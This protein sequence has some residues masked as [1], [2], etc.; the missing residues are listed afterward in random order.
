MKQ[1]HIFFLFAFITVCTINSRAQS[2]PSNWQQ[3]YQK[4]RV[5]I[6]NKG[7]FSAY[8]TPETGPIAYAI[9]FGS[10]RIFFG[11]KGIRYYFLEAHQTA[12]ETRDSLRAIYASQVPVYKEKE[13]VVGK[14]AFKSDA[15]TLQ[16]MGQNEQV[17]LNAEAPQSAY[18]SYPEAS[19]CVAYKRLVYQNI[20]PFI[21]LEYTVHPLDGLKYAF[22]VRPGANPAQIQFKYDRPVS[23]DLHQDI[24]IPTAFGPVR[25]HA[26]F[27]FQGDTSRVVASSFKLNGQT[28]G[29]LVGDYNPAQTLVIDPWTQSPNFATNWDVVWEC[30]RDGAGNAYA[31]GGIMP[32][33][34]LKY[35]PSGTLLWTYSTPYDTSNVWL[36][37]FAVDNAGNAY[38]TA[39]SVA[40]IQKISPAGALLVNNPSPGG[41]LSSA[42]F[43]TI[44]FNCDETGLVIGGTGGALLQLDAVVYNVNTTTLNIS[45]QQFISNGPTTSIPPNLEEVRAITA[46]P[47]G[48]YYFMTHDTI[49]YLSDNFG[50]CPTGT[51]SFYKGPHG[52][53]WGYKCENF[54]YD[55]AGINALATTTNHLYMHRGNEIQKRSLQDGS[56]IQSNSIPGGQ[57][58]SV[59]LGGNQTGCAGLAIDACGNI[60]VGSTTGVVKYDQLLIQQAF[61]PT[62]FAVYDIEIN[63]NGELLV[64]GG[65]GTST[66]STRTGAIRS[67][68]VGAC[69]PIALTCCDAS[70]CQ[71]Q[72]VCQT[73]APIQLVAGTSGGTWSG[74][75]VSAQGLFDPLVAGAGVQTIVYTLPC[76]N[77]SVQ[78]TVSPCTGLQVCLDANGQMSV[79][80][81]VSPYTWAYF[82][83]AVNTPITNQTECQNCG[84]TWFFGQ[85]LNGFTPVTSCSTPAGYVSF[86]TG[87]TA[88]PPAAQNQLQVT[89]NTGT[90]Y[91]FLLSQLAPCVANPCAG[92]SASI[93]TQNNPSCSGAADGSLTLSL[94]NGTA[95]FTYN[96]SPVV[97]TTNSLSN[98]SSGTYTC[99]ITDVNNCTASVSATLSDPAPLQLSSSTQPTPCGLSEGSMTVQVTGAT[100][101]Y[102]YS[103]SPITNTTGTALNL[104]SGIYMVTVTD[105][106]GCWSSITDT[107]SIS[108]G[109]VLTETIT[110]SSCM[111]NNGAISV[112]VSGGTPPYTLIWNPNLGSGPSLSNLVANQTL[113]LSVMDANDCGAFETYLIPNLNDL[114]L[115]SWA[116]S[117]SILE[118]QTVVLS[119]SG[120]ISY[121]WE[122]SQELTCPTCASTNASPIITTQYIVTGTATNGCTDQDTLLITVTQ[123]CGSVFVP[124]ILAPAATELADQTI[125]VYGNCIAECNL[126]IYNRWGEVVFETADQ[127]NCW[128]GTF[129][130]KE[131]HSDVYAYKL[132][133][134]LQDGTFVDQ[135]GSIQLIR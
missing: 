24:L 37:T 30:E 100:A 119:A 113:S 74:P 22:I 27:S 59:F 53:G 50:G 58:A 129:K 135:A 54:R 18:F 70:I 93:Q 55:N 126:V 109:P 8:Q 94:S 106:N 99:A 124:T 110:A 128:D 29:F 23:L 44:A 11:T 69:A 46:A 104:P 87:S 132:Q 41:I 95:P 82:T 1:L 66:A 40:Q 20:Y 115:T 10:T 4:A 36:G 35:N 3:P 19:N 88:P 45:N 60:Y 112:V 89:D 83:P 62:S 118:G 79:T 33:Q 34:I 47:N 75:G 13:Q 103:W 90:V 97:S 127:A 80:G 43:W 121:S 38:V 67:M 61:Y 91:Q 7:Q 49:G 48:K 105:A 2:S 86:A 131:L 85:C 9:D 26:P 17:S 96:W 31:L 108:N 39:G 125:C 5:F 63:T 32:M 12:K 56:L 133:V 77:D 15:F 64:S 16:F 71:P 101:P 111:S 21:D 134:K 68:A 117:T 51:S 102:T 78:I 130:G 92:F 28:V 52:A 123:L 57:F 114:E 25:D 42:E 14:F 84:Y 107:V 122:P 73:D 6:E 98:L 76:G 116:S 120:A 81:G 65:T 72:N